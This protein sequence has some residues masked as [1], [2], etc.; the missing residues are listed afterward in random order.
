MF[1]TPWDPDMGLGVFW[2]GIIAHEVLTVNKAAA[3]ILRVTYG[4][5]SGVA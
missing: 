5:G 4:L 1:E 3:S 2:S